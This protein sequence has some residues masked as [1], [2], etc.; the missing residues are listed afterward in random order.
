MNSERAFTSRCGTPNV[1]FMKYTF[2]VVARVQWVHCLTAGCR[3]VS[4]LAV[5]PIQHLSEITRHPSQLIPCGEVIHRSSTDPVA[6]AKTQKTRSKFAALYS[7]PQ[8]PWSLW[9]FWPSRPSP[10]TSEVKN[11]YLVFFLIQD[12]TSS[13]KPSYS[14]TKSETNDA[15]FSCLCCFRFVDGFRCVLP[16][17]VMTNHSDGDKCK[18]SR[19]YTSYVS[20]SVRCA[21]CP[22]AFIS[23][24]SLKTS[25]TTWSRVVPNKP[26]VRTLRM[27]T[28]CEMTLTHTWTVLR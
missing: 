20:S 6:V 28:S 1:L 3:P 14:I 15:V 18:S 27:Y 4:I 5:H 22:T 13:R 9:Q 17:A 21:P 19:H 8:P 26:G 2:F 7:S 24:R 16:P 12:E 23:Q 10:P 25:Q 11:H